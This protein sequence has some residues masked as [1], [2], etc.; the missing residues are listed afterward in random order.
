MKT[1]AHFLN[2][3][4][5]LAIAG[6]LLAAD[7]R[8]ISWQDLLPEER[9]YH[10]PFA[11]LEYSQVNALAML[12]RIEILHADTADDEKRAEA[13][14]IREDLV[15]QGLDPDWLFEQREIV[16]NQ[17]LIAAREPNLDLLGE[18]VRLPGYLLPLDI[19]DQKAV[20]FLLVPTV[21]ACI[22]TPPPPANQMVYVRYE[23]GFEIDELYKPVW[24][25]G[26]MRAQSRSQSLNYVD[27]QANIETSYAMDALSVEIY[28]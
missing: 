10:D 26:E 1:I 11:T 28:D 20:E 25:S 8:N 22:H 16:M 5:A 3:L 18:N 2:T 17:R 4:F 9:P 21:G 12:Y 7:P 23:Q 19:V 14:Q 24:I 6:P 27:G 13:F 15:S